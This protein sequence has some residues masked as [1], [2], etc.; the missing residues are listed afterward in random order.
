MKNGI[1]KVDT[2]LSKTEILIGATSSFRELILNPEIRGNSFQEKFTNGLN[3]VF[4]ELKDKSD[5]LATMLINNANSLDIIYILRGGL[6]FNIHNLSSLNKTHCEVSFC[7]S[8]RVIEDDK[9]YNSET[10]YNKWNLHDKSLL[11]IGDISATGTTFSF[12]INQAIQQYK[13]ERKKPIG[14]LL[15]TVG[16]NFSI[17]AINNLSKKL[18]KEFGSDFKGI[19]VLFLEG[20]FSLNKGNISYKELNLIDTDFFIKNHP[21]TIEL[22]LERMNHPSSFFERC[23]IY[24]GGSRSFEPNLYLNNL[25]NYWM[26][27]YELSNSINIDNFLEHRTDIFNQNKFTQGNIWK[28]LIISNNN[29]YSEDEFILKTNSTIEKIKDIGLKSLCEQKLNILTNN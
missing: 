5:T 20:I 7:S 1:H 21:R 23:V 19:S 24:D 13:K 18:E 10:S 11:V 28:T 27:I 8:Q 3:N 29:E 6:N 12:I 17:E 9:I 25:T 14:I 15:I 4:E 2:Y 22:E 16:T 26:K